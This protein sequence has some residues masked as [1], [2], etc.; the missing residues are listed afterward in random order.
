M[1]GRMQFRTRG[2]VQAALFAALLCVL[3]PIAIPVGPV[4][5]TLGVFVVL[6][7]GVVLPWK[8][9]S[10][11]VLVYIL[12]GLA[13]LPVFSGGGGGFGVLA[14][15][16]GGYLWCYLP[17]AALVSRLSRGGGWKMAAFA[18]ILGVLLCYLLGTLQFTIVM[19]C[20]WGEALA[21]CVWP[22]VPFDA[23]KIL[24]AALLGTR[25][26]RQLQAAELLD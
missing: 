25:L 14:G 22:F 15:P 26:K 3:S 23:A 6:L 9:A 20:G 21:L 12:I 4:P 2:L 8:R 1:Y 13:G 24:G 17:M 11:A 5:V 18:S 10:A 16:T 19:N 7:A